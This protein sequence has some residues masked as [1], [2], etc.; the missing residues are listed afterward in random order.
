MLDRATGIS[1]EWILLADHADVANG[2]LYLNGG[3]WENLTVNQ[4]L[5][6]SHP[7]GIAVA[8]SIPW[9]ETNQKHP[10]A[11]ALA[12]EDGREF[13]T[14]EGELE[15][16]RPPGIP[17]GQAQRIQM[18]VNLLIQIEKLGAYVVSTRLHGQPSSAITFRAIAGPGLAMQAALKR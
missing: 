8:F 10:M 9:N 15:V 1:T 3:G 13:V 16:G 5:P 14:V 12:D 11:I 18:A 7:C 2:K 4:P 17:L 6:I